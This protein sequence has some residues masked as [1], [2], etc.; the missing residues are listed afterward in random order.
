VFAI[1]N[2]VVASNL[3]LRNLWLLLFPYQFLSDIVEA[4]EE[5]EQ[6]DVLKHLLN[7]KLS[8]KARMVL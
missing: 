8:I 3:L 7:I 5:E 2:C 6:S 4:Q 1:Y